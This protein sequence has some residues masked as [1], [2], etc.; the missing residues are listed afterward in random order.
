VKSDSLLT[1][2]VVCR[3]GCVT[4]EVLGAES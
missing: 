3:V 1:F 2:H 4:V